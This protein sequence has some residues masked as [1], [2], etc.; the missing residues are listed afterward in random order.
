MDTYETSYDT[1]ATDCSTCCAG[2]I[3]PEPV[4]SDPVVSEPV[5]EPVAPAPQPVVEPVAPAAPVVAA[6]AA[7]AAVE[8][9]APAS[10]AFDQVDAT[11]AA[12]YP[13]E[14][15]IGGPSSDFTIVAADGSALANTYALEAPSIIGGPSW[16]TS[17]VDA[18]GAP[19]RAPSEFVVG[20]PIPSDQGSLLA[21]SIF[22]GLNQVQFVPSDRY[23]YNRNTLGIEVPGIRS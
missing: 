20:G 23:L 19:V 12:L 16:S 3:A 17:V 2:P 5:V 6:P 21:S 13:S 22:A 1:T 10:P 8:T 7:P 9:A 18:T 15:T 4:I 11:R 14:T